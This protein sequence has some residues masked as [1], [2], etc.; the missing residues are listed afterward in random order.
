MTDKTHLDSR[1][2][3]P[4]EWLF[5][6]ENHPRSGWRGHPNLGPMADFWLARHQGFR[7]LGTVLD[8]ALAGFREGRLEAR[9]FATFFAPRLQH[10]LTELHHHHMIEDHHYFPVFAAAERRLAAG[11]DLLEADHELIHERIQRVV[12]RANDLLAALGGI[13]RDRVRRAADAYADDGGLLLRGLVRHL[14][15]EEDLIVPLI[16]DRGEGALGVG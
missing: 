1:G 14:D 3:L 8:D 11:F 6:L 13:D 5:L 15:D 16:L 9:S 10:F 7:D 12:G 4:A 2:G